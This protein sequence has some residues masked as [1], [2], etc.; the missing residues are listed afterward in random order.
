M[1]GRG[2]A[3]GD[4]DSFWKDSG[5]SVVDHLSEFEDVPVYHVTGWYDSWSGSVAN[6]NSWN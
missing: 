4:N 1:A 5:T 2:D 3:H 6:L